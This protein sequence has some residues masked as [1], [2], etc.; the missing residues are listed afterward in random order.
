MAKKIKIPRINKKIFP[1]SLVSIH[2]EDIVS[3][4]S[5]DDIVDI[6]KSKTA[7]CCSIGWLVEQNPDRTIVMADYSFEDNKT[8]KVG[9]YS[10]SKVARKI[11]L[12]CQDTKSIM[13]QK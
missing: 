4:S 2:W 8:I 3:E 10:T 1:Y 7:V 11:S 12:D 5:W 13:L 9:T 6:K